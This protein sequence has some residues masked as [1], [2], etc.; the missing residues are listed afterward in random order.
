MRASIVRIG[1]SRG[2]RLPKPLLDLCGI[3]EVVDLA[4]EDGRLIVTPLRRPREGWAEAARAAA[5]VGDDRLLDPEV[6][7]VFDRTGWQW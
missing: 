1:N 6:P 7:T 3:E 4:V 2:L 5:A